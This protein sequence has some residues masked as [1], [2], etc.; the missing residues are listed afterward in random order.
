MKIY[1]VILLLGAITAYAHLF[2]MRDGGVG[3]GPRR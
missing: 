2:A 1:V 3:T